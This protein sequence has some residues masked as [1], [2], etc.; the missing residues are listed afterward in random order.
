MGDRPAALSASTMCEAFQI[1][2]E[3]WAGSPALRLKDS[4]YEASWQDYAEAVRRRAAGL[5]KLGVKRGDTVG[6]MLVNRPALHLTDAAAMHLGATCFSVYNTSSP[7]QVEYVVRDAGNKVIVTEQAFL[8]TV[9]AAREAI[10][11]LEHVVVIDGE[12]PAGTISI[13]ELEEMGDPGFD[14]EATWRAVEPDDVLCLIYTSGTTGP[15]KGVQLTH[16]NMV[17]VWRACDAVQA[18]KP[19]GRMISFLPS[20]HIA[21]RWAGLYA[22]MFYG[23]CVY[24]CPD[25]RQMVAYSIEVKPTVWGGVPRIWEKLKA[26]IEIGIAAEADEAKREATVAA[27]ELGRRRARAKMDGGAPAELEAEWK[28]ADEQVLARIRAMLGLDQVESFV[29][30]AAPTP[31]EVLEFFLALGIEIRE[32]WGMSETTAITTLNPPGGTRVGTVGPPI[33]NTEVKLAE[34]GEVM[35]RGPQ[36]M[37]GYRN[38]PEKTAEALTDDGW[39]LTGD[40]GEFDEK[41]YLRIVDRK[42]ELIINA[43][44]KNMSPANIEAKL[45]AASTLIAQ[46]VTIGDNRPYNV[47]L[48]ALDPESLAARGATPDDPRVAKEITEAVEAANARLSRVEQIKRYKLLSGEW[49]PGGEELTPTMKLK[50][51][52]IERKYEAEIEAL[53]S[54]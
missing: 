50:R 26:A 6:F 53:Y 33:P 40:I 27:I 44:G 5:A 35:V 29:V 2:A 24:C 11:D 7:E 15:P 14:F 4:D 51:R 21:D 32:T 8:E 45:K 19:G 31:P 47:A 36:V 49:L 16:A 38:L 43:A 41:G 37:L 54:A 42:K 1:S 30:G 3:E 46:A 34:D 17:A 52:P 25:P 13:S 18:T 48:I 22:Q 9:L 20:A 12:A 10:D 23:S 39:L 28:H